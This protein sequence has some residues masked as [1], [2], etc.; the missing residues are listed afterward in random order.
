MR[1]RN[2]SIMMTDVVLSVMIVIMLVPALM[3]S[4]AVMHDSLRFNE[5]VQ[6][7]VGL[8]Q[9]RRILLISY[10]LECSSGS[11]QFEY[12]GRDCI[13]QQVNDHL[14]IQPGTQIILADIDSCRFEQMGNTVLLYYER[15]GQISRAAIAA[16]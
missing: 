3:I 15:H 14:I 1:G 13:L 4:V 16:V 9:L 10:D 12:Q 7:E 8:S 2:G 11:L 5:E 6:D